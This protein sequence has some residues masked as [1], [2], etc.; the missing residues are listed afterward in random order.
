M[1]KMTIKASQLW[2]WDHS[3]NYNFITLAHRWRCRDETN[4]LFAV[5]MIISLIIIIMIIIITRHMWCI[6]AFRSISLNARSQF[7]VVFQKQVTLTR[8]TKSACQLGTALCQFG[9]FQHRFGKLPGWKQ[10]WKPS[11]WQ[12]CQNPNRY[13]YRRIVHSKKGEWHN[14]YIQGRP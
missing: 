6:L 10:Q 7:S 8:S 5:L 1:I 2:T 11:S 4:P 12:N 13:T 14:I 3:L 9:T